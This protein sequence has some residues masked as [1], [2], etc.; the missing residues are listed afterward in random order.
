[1]I[2]RVRRRYWLL[3]PLWIAICAALFFAVRGA[4]DPSRRH[5]RISSDEAAVRAVDLLRRAD[6][7]RYRGYEAVHVA[8][9]GRGE[10]GTRA[11]WVVLCDRLPHSALRDAVVVELDARDGSLILIRKP[12]N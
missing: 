10:G 5:D 9:A 6:R 3:Y 8:Y 11:R 7:A 2:P 4:E 12:V 1:M